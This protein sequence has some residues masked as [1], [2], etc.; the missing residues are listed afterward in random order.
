MWWLRLR[1]GVQNEL[2]LSAIAIMEDA[3]EERL[4]MSDLAARLN[5]SPDRLE[6]N[7]RAE[8]KTSPSDYYR[9]L[10]L[11]RAVDLLTHSTL[12]VRDVLTQAD[13]AEFSAGTALVEVGDAYWVGTFRGNRIV[14][15]PMR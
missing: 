14:I 4:A 2:V 3:V 10:R 6:R 12:A 11:R 5:V 8:L 9:R 1:T 7:F 13:S 15:L